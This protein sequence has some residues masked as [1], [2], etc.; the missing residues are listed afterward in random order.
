MWCGIKTLICLVR[1]QRVWE[2][3]NMWAERCVCEHGRLIQMWVFA[4]V[5]CYSTRTPVPR[6][7]TRD[8]VCFYYMG[9]TWTVCMIAV[10]FFTDINECL[11]GEFCFTRGECVNTE[12]S[13]MCV[14]SQGY[15][16]SANGTL[17]QGTC[18][19]TCRYRII[20]P[21]WLQFWTK[22]YP[23]HCFMNCSG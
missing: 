9:L 20:T 13:Y 6:W 16:T 12:G 18:P 4:R 2:L 3:W 8:C 17:C 15:Q 7:E 1:C 5:W 19:G 21:T 14:C 11:E 10:T 22:A 23:C